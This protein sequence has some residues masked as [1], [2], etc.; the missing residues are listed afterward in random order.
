MG[1]AGRRHPSLAPTSAHSEPPEA[2]ER[3]KKK[4]QKKTGQT[5]SAWHQLSSPVDYPP[6]LHSLY[7]G[8]Q[9]TLS[10]QG[11]GL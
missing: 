6:T 1:G 10:L 2:T 11:P 9:G 4:Q 3:G 5:S 7:Q 8:A